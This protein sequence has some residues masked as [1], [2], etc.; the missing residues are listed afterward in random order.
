M[1]RIALF[2]PFF[3]MAC[4]SPEDNPYD[5]Q[6]FG[7]IAGYVTDVD[8]SALDNVKV[9]AQDQAVHTDSNGRFEI[10][11]VLPENDILLTFRK[12][13]YAKGYSTTTIH[14]WETVSASG[15]LLEVDGYGVFDS[16][17]GGLIEVGEMEVEFDANT[18]VDADGNA[19]TGDV[20]VAIAHLDPSSAEMA[21]GP[22]DLQ[23]LAF[24]ESGT[25]KDGLVANQLVSYGMIDVTLT[26]SDGDELNLA[27][28]SAARIEMPITNGELANVY[29]TQAGET[30]QTWSFDP[31]RRR[32]V[33]E[34]I[35]NVIAGEEEGTLRFSFEATHF[36][37]WNADKGTIPT[38]ASG[39]VV[40]Y[41][42]FPVRGAQISVN[43]GG[44]GSQATTDEDGYY[45]VSV[46]AGASS[47]FG[48]RTHVAQRD[49]D[50]QRESVYVDCPSGSHFCEVNASG[51]EGAC[52][53]VPDLQIDVCRIT[54]AVTVENMTS[55][56]DDNIDAI[57]ADHA[58]AVFFEP[59]GDI[60]FC[61]NP[62][63]FIAEEQCQ[64]VH[65]EDFADFLP[66][67]AEIGLP[68]DARSVGSYIEISTSAGE[69]VNLPTGNDRG[70][71]NYEH[72]S[73]SA[74]DLKSRRPNFDGGDVLSV[75]APGSSDYYFGA[76][77]ESRFATMPQS[78]AFQNAKSQVT[79]TTSG[80]EL[81]YN[82]S[83]G[84][85]R[86]LLAFANSANSSAATMCRFTDDGSVRIP[87]QELSQLGA[88]H[89]G[90]GIYHLED[91]YGIGPDGLPI[92]LQLF[93]GAMTSLEL[94]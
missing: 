38:C 86:G 41:L 82:G 11:G 75:K 6:E 34:S 8:G 37:W 87:A 57:D 80:I 17:L 47:S 35:G 26:D 93:S 48:A 74:N 12:D 4:P 21:A 50:S 66:S 84:F 32:W 70:L 90:V 15:T 27:E 7:R 63:D 73:T 69:L 18:I 64:T 72:N 76:W 83:N 13:G 53:P 51:I 60:A 28:D 62:W 30:R 67:S 19:F 2:S 61:Q 16:S 33:E 78:V 39:R 22:G 91:G 77:E 79:N 9:E 88:G 52:Y 25:S 42:G 46:L 10:D 29:R 31:E 54:G 14:S 92:R 59:K 36:S 89:G 5:G 45:V 58:S 71:Y 1:K 40:D 24:D 44:S 55:V 85:N 20:T 43:G 49:W 3:L 65:T 68:T 23:A 94:Q 81:R 56:T